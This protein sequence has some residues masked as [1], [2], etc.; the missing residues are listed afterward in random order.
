MK[1]VQSPNLASRH[2]SR[3]LNDRAERGRKAKEH[4]HHWGAMLSNL[5]AHKQRMSGSHL[6][7]ISSRHQQE[8]QKLR[9]AQSSEAIN[10]FV[11]RTVLLNALRLQQEKAQ[12]REE[13]QI[14]PSAESNYRSRVLT[15]QIADQHSDAP[16]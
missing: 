7:V 12:L 2:D 11:E 8:T 6:R 1:A 13:H 3:M 5:E 16:R 4:D 9:A 15:L 14:P 10:G